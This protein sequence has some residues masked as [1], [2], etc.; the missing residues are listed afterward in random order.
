MCVSV[1]GWDY[2]GWGFGHLL[3]YGGSIANMAVM[4]NLVVSKF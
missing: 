2:D 4:E 3:T 1:W